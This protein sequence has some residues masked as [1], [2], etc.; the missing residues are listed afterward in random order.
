MENELLQLKWELKIDETDDL[1]NS[2]EHVCGF[3]H[4]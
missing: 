2:L 1:E 4:N 3:F